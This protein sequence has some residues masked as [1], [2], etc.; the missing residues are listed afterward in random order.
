M[1]GKCCIYDYEHVVGHLGNCYDTKII[2]TW[3]IYSQKLNTSLLVLLYNRWSSLMI[4]EFECTLVGG[5]ANLCSI[6]PLKWAFVCIKLIEK[7]IPTDQM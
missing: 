5:D 1:A 3:I 4:A 6:R 2:K 7:S